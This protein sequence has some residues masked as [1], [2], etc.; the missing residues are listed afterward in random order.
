M[1]NSDKTSAL[2]TILI[3]A[4]FAILPLAAS[5]GK[6]A[7]PATSFDGLELVS[8]SKRS[9]VYRKPNVDFTVY[10]KVAIAPSKVAFKENWKRDY[11]RSQRSLSGRVSDRDM[12][13]IKRDLAQLFDEVFHQEL[14][15][16]KGF[17]LTEE[18]GEGVLLIKP[19]VIN[20]D[21][22]APDVNTATRSRTYV[23]YA[24]EGT[25]YLE[26]FDGVSGDILARAVDVR[27][28]RDHNYFRWATRVTNRA[29]ARALLQTWAKKLHR[30]LEEVHAP[31]E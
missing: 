3:L 31:A 12:E 26:V 15:N 16:I 4:A 24:G 29:D 10:S 25:L 28:T 21:I 27:K 8:S 30:K 11:N 2:V 6:E 20:L 22:N 9:H 1:H 23:E 13:R 5:A 19:A 14:Q 18:L 17:T 7:P